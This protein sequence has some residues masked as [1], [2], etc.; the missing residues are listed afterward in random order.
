[1]RGIDGQIPG[2]K[3]QGKGEAEA[4][5]IER[6]GGDAQTD[7]LRRM[8]D[9]L[10]AEDTRLRQAC[11]WPTAL[12]QRCGIRAI[13]VLG[14][15]YFDK[16]LVLQA[17][18]PVF[19]NAVFFTTDLYADMLHPQDNPFTRNLVVASGYG[20]TPGPGLAARGP[21]AARQLPDRPA[22]DG[23]PG[24][25]GH[26]GHAAPG[27]DPTPAAP[28]RDRAHPGG[29]AGHLHRNATQQGGFRR[30][31][32][33][34][35]RGSPPGAGPGGV[36]PAAPGRGPRRPG[37]RPAPGPA[38]RP[39]PGAGGPGT[40]AGPG[41]SGGRWWH[42]LHN[43]WLPSAIAAFSLA[44][45]ALLLWLL[46]R[47]LAQ[48]GEPF[49]LLEGVSVWPSEIL[50]LVAGLVAVG[51]FIHGHR[52][53]REA[54]EGIERDFPGAGRRAA[55]PARPPGPGRGNGDWRPP[56][57]L[58][59]R[60][61]GA[62]GRRS[63]CPGGE[64]SGPAT[65]GAAA[66]VQTLRRV[67]PEI[68]GLPAAVLHPDAGPGLPQPPNPQRPLLGPGPRDRLPGP[69]PV[70]RPSLLHGGRHPPDP[71]PGPG[72]AGPASPGPRRPWPPWAWGPGS[73]TETGRPWVRDIVWLDVRL[74]AAVT[75]PVGNLVWYPVVVLILIALARHPLFDAWSLPPALILVMAL[76]IAYAVGCAWTLRR[77]AEGVRED[78]VHQLSAA[79]LRAQGRADAKECLEPL[80]TMLAAVVAARD[81]AFRPFSQQ[82]V[83]QALLTLVSSV[84]G[85]A[86]L[87]Y[88]S[89]ANL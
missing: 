36:L 43:G 74:I 39:R 25:A 48:G 44:A 65:P 46:G 18:K 33:A 76:A 30:A 75:R 71:E 61:P 37:G 47:D 79:L 55:R 15:D 9:A 82:P 6:P 17:L 69:D 57:R 78:A 53:Q 32:V 34:P 21:A 22:A 87:E 31:G 27:P 2:A 85:L 29:G 73:Q 66:C 19:P 11:G 14:N 84:S 5:V 4:Q 80:R 72:P 45:S 68:L 23:A 10:L 20:L 86:L 7:Y 60:G 12:R 40:A 41:G 8:R 67:W 77:A 70:S 52:R 28:V 81:G 62:P 59:L 42:G 51:L 83:V 3:P 35:G 50:R 54:R 63:P 1:M 24:G 26:P 64:P 88:S 58:A 38:A 49:S 89:L 56:R 16:L 13:G